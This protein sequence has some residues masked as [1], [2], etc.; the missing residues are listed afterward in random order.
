MSIDGKIDL[1]EKMSEVLM[2]TEIV[3]DLGMFIFCAISVVIV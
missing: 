1:V 3:I 2:C